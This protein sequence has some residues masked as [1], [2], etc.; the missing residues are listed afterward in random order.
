MEKS[1][2]LESPGF[3]GKAGAFVFSVPETKRHYKATL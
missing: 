3:Y 1:D 2:S